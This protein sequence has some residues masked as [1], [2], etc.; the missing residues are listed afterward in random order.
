MLNVL[1]SLNEHI[2]D[3]KSECYLNLKSRG[4]FQSDKFNINLLIFY[5]DTKYF[6]ALLGNILE[7][8]FETH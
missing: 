2:W 4:L 6:I 3:L 8:I 7:K 5:K 1:S